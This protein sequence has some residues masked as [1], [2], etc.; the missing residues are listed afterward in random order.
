M[1]TL[2][3]RGRWPG[4]SSTSAPEM[5]RAGKNGT[6]AIAESSAAVA[7]AMSWSLA[8]WPGRHSSHRA[9]S[10]G[11][12]TV[13]HPV[14]LWNRAGGGP[15]GGGDRARADPEELWRAAGHPARRPG[16]LVEFAVHRAGA[17]LGDHHPG[18]G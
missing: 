2:A 10:W 4:S 7:T 16:D 8:C 13:P 1:G 11:P 6:H 17:D 3:T 18:A 15:A 9:R 5:A 12:A 14:A